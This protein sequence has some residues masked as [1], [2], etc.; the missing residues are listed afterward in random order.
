MAETISTNNSISHYSPRKPMLK[1]GNMYWLIVSL[2]KISIID[3]FYDSH[4]KIQP[5]LGIF[6]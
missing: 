3:I 6:L 5:I 4:H 2:L 1:F